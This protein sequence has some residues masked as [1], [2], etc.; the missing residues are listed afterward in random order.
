MEV[1]DFLNKDS[2]IDLSFF[3]FS[4]AVTAAY[5]AKKNLEVIKVNS[6]FK[7]FFPVLENV[8][9]IL[10][11]SILDQ[12]GVPKEQIDNFE[13]ELKENGKVIIPKIEINIDGKTKIYSLLS[14]YTENDNFPYLDEN[15][16][17]MEGELFL[18]T[19]ND[20]WRRLR[21]AVRESERKK[22][23]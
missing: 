15:V 22:Q 16:V 9:N 14:A 23:D 5:F 8:T 20:V 17:E 10:F 13:K 12:L 18:E 4:N 7:K 2:I 19:E 11:P 6:N 21:R 3:N 1:K